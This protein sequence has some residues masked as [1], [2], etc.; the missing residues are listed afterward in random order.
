MK[1]NDQEIF[2]ILGQETKR[3]KETIELIASENFV[4][5]EVLEVTGSIFTNKY[6][7]G[8]PNA[9][10]YGGCANVDKVEQLA[11]DRVK[12]LFD[13]KFANVQTHS[14]S[15][16]NTAAYYSILEPGDKILGMALD[17]GGH[18][19]HGHKV[20]FS[21]KIYESHFYV[22]D[23]ETEMIDYDIVLKRAKEVKPKLIIAGASAYSRIIDFKKFREIADEVEAY[24]LVDMAHIAGLIAVGLQPSPMEYADIVTSTTHKTLRGARGGLI[25]TNKKEIAQKID[26][27]VF[28]GNQ[29]GPLM[30]VI[31][32]K[33]I[34]FYEALQPSYKTYIKSVVENSKAMAEEFIANGARVVTGGTDNHLFMLDIKKTY[35]I[36][37]QD[38]EDALFNI[39]IIVNKN[40][41]PFDEESPRVTSGIRIGTP[42]MTTHGFTKNDFIELAKII[43]ASLKNIKDKKVQDDCKDKVNKLLK[44]K[45]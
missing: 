33:A 8:Y 18:L 45:V 30:H 32:G 7:E 6:A 5:K 2:D 36:T 19:T 41:I 22:V 16:A 11:I 43:D 39:N 42:A 28:P 4:S 44:V 9:R 35:D 14:G 13:A 3:Q 27:A 24:L 40:T 21:G 31:A 26:K 29:G 38:A 15:Q 10:Y 23:K 34:A 12:K 25:L 20:N 1:R 37:G 17:C